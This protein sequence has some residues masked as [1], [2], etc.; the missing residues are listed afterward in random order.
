MRQ[1]RKSDGK[2]DKKVNSELSLCFYVTA[3]D[4]VAMNNYLVHLPSQNDV[5]VDIDVNKEMNK[6]VNGRYFDVDG[7]DARDFDD[8][9]W[10]V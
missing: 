4:E 1:T 10:E 5:I 9:M 7:K 8:T 6:R 3:D 2:K